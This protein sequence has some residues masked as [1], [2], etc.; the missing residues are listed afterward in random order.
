M[1]CLART[2]ISGERCKNHTKFVLCRKHKGYWV[3]IIGFILITLPGLFGV[4]GPIINSLWPAHKVS[5]KSE[6]GSGDNL[7]LP[8]NKIGIFKVLIF[9]FN[10]LGQSDYI[11]DYGQ[12][13]TER[14]GKFN[15]EDSLGAE[16]I[17]LK[18]FKYPHTWNQKER[19]S[20]LKV[21]DA[22][23]LIW[24]DYVTEN[25]KGLLS[26]KYYSKNWIK[27][28][29]L[30]ADLTPVNIEDFSKGE[31][32]GDI[33]YIL[34]NCCGIIYYRLLAKLSSNENG[35]T[36]ISVRDKYLNKT[37][38]LI[39]YSLKKAPGTDKGVS[40]GVLGTCYLFSDSLEKS[41]GCF[42]EYLKKFPND[43]MARSNLAVALASSKNFQRAYF[44]LDKAIRIAPDFSSLYFQ[45]GAI[46]RFQGNLFLSV[47]YYSLGL[48]KF[49][50]NYD[51]RYRRFETYH[52]IADRFKKLNY[53]DS[54]I[55]DLNKLI[56][57][58]PKNL[59]LYKIKYQINF[60][61]NYFSNVISDINQIERISI[62]G[63]DDYYTRGMAYSHLKQYFAAE[64][65]FNSAISLQ[66]S[67][68]LPYYFLSIV[69][70]SQNDTMKAMQLC[71][72]ILSINRNDTN[73]L[74]NRAGLYIGSGRFE[75]AK[76]DLTIWKNITH[77]YN[78]ILVTKMEEQIRNKKKN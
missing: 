54:A 36:A 28:K 71:N 78:D 58:K 23:L 29:K 39:N 74:F 4:Y 12:I 47:N 33:D 65:D 3:P 77:R 1:R 67:N 40:F 32:Q 42:N 25:A 73:T 24:G 21:H 37:I 53:E 13:I 45:R 10:N 18:D 50:E 19:D 14:F 30:D 51:I 35:D 43:V 17:Y 48:Q 75:E 56:E 68:L 62:P 72:K 41:I 5:S 11:K 66:P 22:D 2:K 31:I 6:K 15:E 60:H 44:E 70:I 20:V 46:A 49:P 52:L 38:K 57:L 61:R 76:K 9:P 63:F 26:L 16:I 59:E 64:K 34:Y 27:Y 55:L 7:I 8:T 69:Y